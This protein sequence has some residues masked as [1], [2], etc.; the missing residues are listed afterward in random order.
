MKVTNTTHVTGENAALSV[1][2][3]ISTYT[4]KSPFDARDSDVSDL[5][6]FS[7]LRWNFVYQRPQHLL[8]RAAKNYRI[9]FFEEPIWSDTLH[10]SSYQQTDRITVLVPHIPH[11]TKP[12]ETVRLQ[13]QLLDEFMTN[14]HIN[15]FVAWYY[16]P[17]ALLF[18]DHLKPALTVYDCMD[19][20]S[21]FWGA[22]V[23]LLEKEK[24][25][26]QA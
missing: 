24:Q 25:L 5:I 2:S 21:A 11:G 1:P 8:S 19:E 23:Q 15:S 6:C 13:R 20:L 26:S 17:M 18:S 12:D 4:H 3:T 10:M 14:E 16:T 7:H 22:P 9:W